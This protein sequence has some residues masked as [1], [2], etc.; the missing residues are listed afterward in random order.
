MGKKGVLPAGKK[1][2]QPLEGLNVKEN[3]PQGG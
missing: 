3:T 1:K 2:K